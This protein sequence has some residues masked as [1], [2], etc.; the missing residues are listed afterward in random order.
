M[1]GA[2]SEGRV[3]FRSYAIPIGIGA[4]IA[5]AGTVPWPI[6]ASLNA[7]IRPDIPWAAL[8]MAAYLLV[9]VIWLDGLGPPKRWQERRQRL[10]RLWAPDRRP[11][12]AEATEWLPVP[13][14]LALLA[15][16][17]LA[18][19]AMSSMGD[20]VDLSGYPTTAHRLSLLIM[21][22]IVAAVVEEAAFR[23]YMQSGLEKFG[24]HKAIVVTSIVFTLFH[25]VHGLGALALL[26]PGIFAASWLYGWLA[27]RTSTILP[28]VA[29]HALG[30]LSHTYFGVLGGDSRL[31]FVS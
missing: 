4:A 8:A 7:T 5:I 9:F 23:G 31:L 25:A 6:L 27:V 19:I 22:P 12:A 28:G 14:I 10:L 1:A 3:S 18:W 11:S 13:A 26:G 21:S 29:I 2:D 15:L 16:L 17:T 20:P 30:D 24:V